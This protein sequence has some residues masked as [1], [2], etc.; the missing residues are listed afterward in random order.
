VQRRD[1]QCSYTRTIRQQ[2]AL[3]SAPARCGKPLMRR[4]S[5]ITLAVQMMRRAMLSALRPVTA[6]SGDIHHEHDRLI[7]AIGPHCA[8]GRLHGNAGATASVP[9]R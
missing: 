7:R 3:R 6:A 5:A 4:S 8:R 2:S 9:R 1:G